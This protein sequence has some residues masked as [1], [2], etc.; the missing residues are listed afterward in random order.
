MLASTSVY[1]VER[2]PK[3]GCHQC[4]CLQ[5]VLQFTLASPETPQDQQVGLTQAPFKFLLLP[6]V[7]E[8]VILWAQSGVSISHSLKVSPAGLLSQI[9]LGIVFPVKDP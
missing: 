2:A 6:W 3:N 9:F 8:C 5:D 1:M 7:L 4:L